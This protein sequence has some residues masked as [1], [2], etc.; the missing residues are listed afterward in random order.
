MRRSAD[1]DQVFPLMPS[2]TSF[3]AAPPPT[4]KGVMPIDAVSAAAPFPGSKLNRWFRTEAVRKLS[5]R[6][7]TV[8]QSKN[9][10]DF[11]RSARQ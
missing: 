7:C 1:R 5:E 3:V 4:T 11:S 10:R 6:F 9:F 2:R 8:V